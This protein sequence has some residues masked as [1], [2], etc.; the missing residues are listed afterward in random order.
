MAQK[1][2]HNKTTKPTAGQ[3]PTL[4]DTFPIFSLNSKSLLWEKHQSPWDTGRKKS[5]KF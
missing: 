5:A 1:N 2:K 3:D 4:F